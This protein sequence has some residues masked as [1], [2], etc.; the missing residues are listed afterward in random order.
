MLF[1]GDSIANSVDIAKI[2]KE[3]SSRI[4]TE[5]AYSSIHDSRSRWP[6]KNFNDMT[7]EAL[8]NVHEGD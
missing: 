8:A 7:P 6:N 1:V 2:E 5:R 4:K 3:T